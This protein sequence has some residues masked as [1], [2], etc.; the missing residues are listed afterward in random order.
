MLHIKRLLRLTNAYQLATAA[1]LHRYSPIFGT[2]RL[3]YWALINLSLVH[4]L[5]WSCLWTHYAH[6]DRIHVLRYF[7]TL[8][9]DCIYAHL[10]VGLFSY[11]VVV[12][13][14]RRYVAFGER[15]QAVVNAQGGGFGQR[16]HDAELQ[17][18]TSTTRWWRRRC[19]GVEWF[20]YGKMWINTVVLLGLVGYNLARI[21]W[22]TLTRTK[23]M[24]LVGLAYPHMLVANVL[25][26]YTVQAMVVNAMWADE[27]GQLRLLTGGTQKNSKTTATTIQLEEMSPS[28]SDTTPQTL[29]Q[30]FANLT[31]YQHLYS[32][33]NRLVQLQLGL[34]LKKHSLV[35]FIGVH[36]YVKMR[37]VWHVVMTELDQ[38]LVRVNLVTFVVMML[39][40]YVGL[41]GVSLV[42]QREVS[43]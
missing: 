26:F 22:S 37:L 4:G 31:D 38:H 25:R 40:D 34:L 6:Q 21:D 27:N 32:G 17:S 13:E 35:V 11:A 15:V 41:L 43:V 3:S 8:L 10:F 2:F 7:S 1:T 14:Y 19:S 30:H 24:L 28:S 29:R 12:L 5:Y 39:N 16:Q 23:V 36:M 18:A 42:C 20:V 33:L 9:H